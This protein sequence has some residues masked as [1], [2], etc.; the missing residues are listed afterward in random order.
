MLTVMMQAVIMSHS[1]YIMAD[2]G[3]MVTMVAMIFMMMVAMFMGMVV[4]VMMVIAM[5]V[6]AMGVVMVIFT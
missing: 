4:V 3:V 5:N 6:V 1:V 2:F